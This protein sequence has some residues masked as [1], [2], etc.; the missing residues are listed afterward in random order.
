[1]DRMP[2]WQ[3]SSP[4]GGLTQ[5]VFSEAGVKPCSWCAPYSPCWNRLG[6][7]SSRPSGPAGAQVGRTPLS[8]EDTQIAKFIDRWNAAWWLPAHRKNKPSLKNHHFGGH[9]ASAYETNILDS[10]LP[11][12]VAYILQEV[13][14]TRCRAGNRNAYRAGQHPAPEW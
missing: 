10:G 4:A 14:T 12:H 7:N 13:V 1:M 6:K 3:P 9:S 2:A 11:E 8:A 5:E